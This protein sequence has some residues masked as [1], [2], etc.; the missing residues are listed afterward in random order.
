MKRLVIALATIGISSSIFAALPPTTSNPNEITVPQLTGGLSIGVTGLY[1]Q[2]AASNGDLDYASVNSATSPNFQPKTA[3]VDSGHDFGWGVNLG[4][5]FPNTGNDINVNYLHLDTS[6]KDSIA[7][8]NITPTDFPVTFTSLIPGG[9]TT[10]T[11]SANAKAEFDLDQVD[12]TVGQYINVGSRLSLH[13]IAGLRFVDLQRK[14]NATYRDSISGPGTTSGF[15]IPPF[16]FPAGVVTQEKSDFEGI[17]PLVGIDSSYYVGGGFGLVG[18][19][20][21]SLLVGNVDSQLTA[22]ISTPGFPTIALAPIAANS[23]SKADSNHRI[24]PNYDAKLGVDY[25]Y[26]FNNQSNLTFEVG[27]Q[28]SHYY[29]AIDLLKTTTNVV[30]WPNPNVVVFTP[31]VLAQRSTADFSLDGVYANLTLHV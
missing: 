8:G 23:I 31:G 18:H 7:G 12:L 29:K 6:D 19:F 22:A 17:G 14:L 24:V 2:P 13:P 20:S 1:I 4:Y 5:V 11:L 28:V 21:S 3:S 10:T 16:S 25:T 30:N 26:S 27:Y 9:I 15:T